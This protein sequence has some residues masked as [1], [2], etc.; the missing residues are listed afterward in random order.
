MAHLCIAE[1]EEFRWYWRG[2]SRAGLCG[3]MSS[4]WNIESLALSIRVIRFSDHLEMGL[5]GILANYRRLKIVV[6]QYMIRD[7]LGV[8]YHELHVSNYEDFSGLLGKQE[9]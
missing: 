8:W 6:R 5:N 1:L 4:L 3:R 7:T 2:W 9:M